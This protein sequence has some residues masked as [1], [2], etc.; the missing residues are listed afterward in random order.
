MQT[1]VDKYTNNKGYFSSNKVSILTHLFPM[2]LFSTPENIRK[3]YGFLMFSGGRE[4]VYWEQM[5]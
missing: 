5:V 3:S 2:H 1:L 4:N